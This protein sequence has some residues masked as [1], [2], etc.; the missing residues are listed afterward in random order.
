M[1]SSTAIAQ[2]APPLIPPAPTGSTDVPYPSNASGDAVVLI[3]LVVEKD[4]TVSGAQVL[5]GA[6]PFAEQARGAVLTWRF[7]PAR[8]GDSPVA[9]R[10]R[11]RVE[12]HQDKASDAS[13]PDGAPPPMPD[14][15][16][17]TPEPSAA[18]PSRSPSP[19]GPPST[20]VASQLA[21]P[22]ALAQTAAVPE[23]PLDVTVRGTRHEIGQTTLSAADVREMPGAFGDPFRAIEALPGVIPLVSGLPY[24]YIRGAPPNDTGY[25][26]DGV[27]VPFLFH[28]GIGEGVIHPALVDRVDLYPGAPPAAY[29][30]YAGA[31][32]AGETRDPASK[33][34][35]EANLRL[36]D[37]GALVETPLDDGRGSVL[38][39][40]RYGYP[41]A[42]LGLI[43]QSVKLSY[44]DYQARAIWRFTGSD[45]LGV[46]AFGSHDY[47]GTVPQTN[48]GGAQSGAPSRTAQSNKV[49]E[50]LGSDFHRIDLRYDRALEGGHLRAAVTLGYDAQGGGG[51]SDGAPPATITD[52]STAVRLEIDKKVSAWFRI[53]G[54]ADA[55]FDRYSFEQGAGMPD[56]SGV[57]Q[58]PVPSSADPPPTNFTGGAHVDVVWRVA[59]RVEIVPGARVDF[60]QSTRPSAPAGDQRGTTVP[61]FDPRLSARV[62]VT[63]AVA[64][65][66][67]VGISHQYPS[68]RVGPLPGLLLSVP[69]FPFGETKL[70]R[71]VQASQGVEVMLPADLVFI[72]TG[73]LSLWSGLTDLTANCVQIMPPTTPPPDRNALPPAVPYTC[74]D[75]RPVTGHAYGLEVLV[76]RP[77]SKRLTGWLSYTLSR[78][79]R[80]AH[81][82]TLTGGDAAATVPSESDRT[83]ILNA[84]LAYDL[85]RRWRAGARF[86]YYTGAPYSDLSG[87]VPVPPYNDHRGPPF[88]R[89]DVRLEKRWSLGRNRSLAFVLEGLN[90]TLSR[91]V[92]TLG[93]DCQGMMGP[94]G[95]TTQCTP[96]H[97]GP[98]TIPSVGVE[99]IF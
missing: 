10:I 47:L 6:E 96:S 95:G 49:I 86:V 42:I 64:L 7:A 85:G 18:A 93:M 43:T 76:R 11:A 5:E 78:S 90:V 63:P 91:E 41:G 72:A 79:M 35:G 70:Q 83:H 54:G 34:H 32:V 25:F 53:R 48:G 22:K 84:I 26:I 46:F 57:I 88:F 56:E 16:P 14:A 27:R 40:G 99:A 23:T 15:A 82:V 8:R 52:L 69:G 77:L 98:L 33:P 4:G 59:P 62:S 30:G 81:F 65:L 19:A 44:W 87:N 68:L 61:A 1:A 97:F 67:T 39:A 50:Q 12:F 37:A 80:E 38:V 75:E 92:T 94:Q 58:P 31:I 66:S 60:F 74:P 45:S 21:T 2:V 51:E 29:G 28:V 17:G 13:A 73:F 9:A 20:P 36:F 89:V 24:F 55:R 3:E 71:A